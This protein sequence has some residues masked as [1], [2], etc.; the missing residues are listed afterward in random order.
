LLGQ[1]TQG[2]SPAKSQ[3][4]TGTSEAS[5]KNKKSKSRGH[6][7]T[8]YFVYYDLDGEAGDGQFYGQR[9]YFKLSENKLIKLDSSNVYR[10]IRIHAREPITFVVKNFNPFRYAVSI[11]D[12]LFTLESQIPTEFKAFFDRDQ[13]AQLASKSA[14]VKSDSN[15]LMNS[16]FTITVPPAEE[17]SKKKKAQ[18]MNSVGT[19]FEEIKNIV[20]NTKFVSSRAS[21]FITSIRNLPSLSRDSVKAE[22]F[23]LNKILIKYHRQSEKFNGSVEKFVISYF[24]EELGK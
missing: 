24:E 20:S 7:F 10:N 6:D 23:E 21:G 8:N 2:S 4:G 3:L 22:L 17:K 19:E 16:L 11:N 18:E 9:K 12:S 5:V 13:F 14:A 1:A 15:Q